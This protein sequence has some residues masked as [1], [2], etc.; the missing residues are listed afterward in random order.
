LSGDALEVYEMISRKLLHAAHNG[1][2]LIMS[3][4]DMAEQELDPEK[5]HAFFGKAREAVQDLAKLLDNHVERKERERK[6]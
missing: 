5:R 1:L 4:I 6:K 3:L 2:Q